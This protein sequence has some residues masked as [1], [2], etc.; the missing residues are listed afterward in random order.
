MKRILGILA[1]VALVAMT[2]QAVEVK[3]ENVAG[4]ISV[5][6]P[7]AGGYT[8]VSLNLDEFD[9]ADQT[10]VGVFDGILRDGLLPTQ[11]D[12]VMLYDTGTSAYRTFGFKTGAGLK[13]ISASGGWNGADTNASL[14]AGQ[15]FWL[16][17]GNSATAMTVSLTGQAVEAATQSTPIVINWQLAGYPFSCAVDANTTG[18]TNGTPHTLPTQCD[19]LLVWNGVDGYDEYGLKGAIGGDS[20][21]WYST[22]DWNAGTQPVVTLPLGYGFWYKAK[23]A[24]SWE[25]GNKYLANL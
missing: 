19:K 1:V 22:S 21:I 3:S 6:L 7:A 25:E 8:L 17:S 9:P 5:D 24:F 14:V 11:C 13:E 16:R 20:G 15:A 10:I 12:R 23:G 4:V 18:L 2:V